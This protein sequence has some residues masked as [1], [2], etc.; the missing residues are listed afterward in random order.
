MNNSSI[1]LVLGEEERSE[2]MEMLFEL[3]YLPLMRKDILNALDK[4][5]HEKCAAVFLDQSH[6]DVDVLE[7]ILNVRDIDSRI[8]VIVVGQLEDESHRR[9]IFRQEH[10]FLLNGTPANLKRD[11][12]KVLINYGPAF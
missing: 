1:V 8:P 10:L 4:I 5:R 6:E 3:G 7:F 9:I 11:I 2:L 12:Q